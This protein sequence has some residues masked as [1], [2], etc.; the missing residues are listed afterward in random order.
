MAAI[1][2]IALVTPLS[3]SG[4]VVGAMVVTVIVVAL[5]G[6]WQWQL[7]AAIVVMVL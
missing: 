1:V 2:V 5:S 7:V 4:F 6:K 3:S